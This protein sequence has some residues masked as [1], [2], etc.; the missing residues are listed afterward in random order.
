MGEIINKDKRLYITRNVQESLYKLNELFN[1]LGLDIE[2]NYEKCEAYLNRNGKRVKMKK[3]NNCFYIESGSDLV[4][5]SFR[6]TN[7]MFN[8]G[9]IM[10]VIVAKGRDVKYLEYCQ[11][12]SLDN[13]EHPY[14]IYLNYVGGKLAQFFCDNRYVEFTKGNTINFKIASLIRSWGID[15][16]HSIFEIPYYHEFGCGTKEESMYDDKLMKKGN[17]YL[18]V[19]SLDLVNRFSGR[20]RAIIADM[21][22]CMYEDYEYHLKPTKKMDTTRLAFYDTFGSKTLVDPNLLENRAQY[23]DQRC[24]D[25]AMKILSMD[26]AKRIYNEVI[27]EIKEENAYEYIYSYFGSLI[28]SVKSYQDD[29]KPDEYQGAPIHF[30]DY[31]K[32]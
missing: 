26:E 22:S 4:G 15:F 18:P 29:G 11:G 16:K 20:K 21:G 13:F 28:D 23:P 10:E 27:E 1:T 7:L 19:A 17:I 3:G 32:K 24:V 14:T 9:T 25:F 30:L 2:Y 5:Y 31:K 6:V 12:K 8:Y